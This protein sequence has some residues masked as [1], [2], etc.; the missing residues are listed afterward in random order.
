ME[1]L[2]Q[3]SALRLNKKA[4]EGDF[5]LGLLIY[6]V[7]TAVRQA[8][9][10]LHIFLYYNLRYGTC[11]EPI[12]VEPVDSTGAFIACSVIGDY[13]LYRIGFFHPFGCRLKPLLM[14]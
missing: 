4:P 6:L 10:R 5:R 11:Q 9:I 1:V 3:C 13:P 2:Q 14:F 12:P 7:C 8:F